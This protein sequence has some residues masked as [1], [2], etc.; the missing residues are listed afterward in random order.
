[1]KLPLLL[2]L[3][4]L[5]ACA[6]VQERRCEALRDEYDDAGEP[7]TRCLKR[8]GASDAK[9]CEYVCGHGA[10]IQAK[11][12]EVCSDAPPLA[13]TAAPVATSEAQ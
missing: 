10:Q 11:A 2:L 7:C 5:P 3:C 9:L 6:T 12:V 13:P 1:M 8:L 4:C